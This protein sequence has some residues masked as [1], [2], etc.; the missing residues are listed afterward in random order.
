[1]VVIL[2]VITIFA[3]LVV[4]LFVQSRQRQAAA[5][6]IE[7]APIEAP[8]PDQVPAG[9]YVGPGHAWLQLERNGAVAVGVDRLPLAMLG[10]LDRVDLKPPGTEVRRGEALAVLGHGERTLTVPSPVAGTVSRTNPE[11][12][13]DLQQISADP[14]GQGWLFQVRPR[15]LAAT[16]KQMFLAEE[17][18]EWMR[19]ELSRLRD[20]LMSLGREAPV[21]SLPDGGLPVEGLAG[22]LPEPA[23]EELSEQFFTLRPESA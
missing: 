20:V 22:T 2:V 13:H 3:F 21:P 4:G 8:S 12:Q 18:V 16:I 14:F 5:A 7:A 9:T 11:A 15:G 1:M 23:W 17:G 10:G 19:Q 6:P